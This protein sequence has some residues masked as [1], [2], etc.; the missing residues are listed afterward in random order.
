M[1][2]L[3]THQEPRRVPKRARGSRTFTIVDGAF[4]AATGS[5]IEIPA[6]RAPQDFD[7]S[8]NGFVGLWTTDALYARKVG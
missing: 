7:A 1:I 8:F 4:D 3:E 6:G 2:I 5:Q